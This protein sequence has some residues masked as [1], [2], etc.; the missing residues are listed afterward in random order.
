MYSHELETAVRLGLNLTVI[1][2]NDEA[3]GMIKWKQEEMGFADFGLD[4]KNPDFIKYA[5]SFGAKGFRPDSD[6][7]FKEILDKC[8]V[9]E[10]VKIIDLPVDYS[11]NHPI[12]NV[13]LKEKS[14]ELKE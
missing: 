14:R 2:L 9:T 12:L 11:L 1:I 8:L 3:Y 5:E 10:G 13:K 7:N 4:Y 6:Q